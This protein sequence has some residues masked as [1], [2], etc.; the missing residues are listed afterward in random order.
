[1]PTMGER[2]ERCQWQMKRAERVAAVEKIKGKRKPADFF[3]HRNRGSNATHC[4]SN[5]QSAIADCLPYL[6]LVV[7]KWLLPKAGATSKLKIT[8]KILPLQLQQ[9]QSYQP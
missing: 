2:C 9:I 4:D 3:G 8:S 6:W 1:M 5:P 7:R